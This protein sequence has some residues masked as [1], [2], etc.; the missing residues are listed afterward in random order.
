MT[1]FGRVVSQAVSVSP[2]KQWAISWI[3]DNGQRF[4][5]LMKTSKNSANISFEAFYVLVHES[6]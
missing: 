6:D 2:Q 5:K 4:T 1:I 3:Y